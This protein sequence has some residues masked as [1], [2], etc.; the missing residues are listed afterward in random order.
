MAKK[1]IL[2]SYE[3]DDP[4]FSSGLQFFKPISTLSTKSFLKNTN[5]EAPQDPMSPAIQSLDNALDATYRRK[6]LLR[7][8]ESNTPKQKEAPSPRT[9]AQGTKK[10]KSPE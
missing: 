7:E 4:I 2:R 6:G 9:L 3:K 5:G 1:I 10:Q 8:K